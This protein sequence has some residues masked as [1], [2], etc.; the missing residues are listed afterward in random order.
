ME[1]IENKEKDDSSLR[2]SSCKYKKDIKE[3]KQKNRNIYHNIFYYY[4][5][6]VC[7]FF[8]LSFIIFLVDVCQ[9][10]KVERKMKN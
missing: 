2:S 5:H 6:A 8:L 4:L 1:D 9:S 3:I 7:L 10:I